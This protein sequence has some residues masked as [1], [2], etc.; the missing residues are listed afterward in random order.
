MAHHKVMCHFSEVQMY[1]LL[2]VLIYMAFI[3]LGLPDSL[4][5]S[6]WPVMHQ[7][8]GVSISFMGILSMIISGGTIISSLMS[9]RITKKLGTNK[10]TAISVFLTAIA[11]MGFSYAKNIWWLIA[12]AIPYGLGAGSIDAA[13]NNYVAIHYSSKHMSWLH[14]F[15]GVGTIISPFIMSYSLTNY[16]WNNGYSI[17]SIIQFII[18]IILLLTLPIWKV[19]S[20]SKA[21][22]EIQ[23]ES[24]GFITALKIK[25]VPSLLIGFFSYCAAECTAMSWSCTYLVNARGIDEPTAAAFA[26]MF[27]IGMTV[28]R[29]IGGFFMDTLGD[30]RMIVLGSSIIGI[31][32]I[33]MMIPN[34]DSLF[35]LIGLIVIGLGCAPIYPCIIHATP[36]NFGPEKSGAIIGIQ[37]ASAYCGATFIPPIFGL[38]SEFVGFELFPVYMAVFFIL[39]LIMVIRTF[40]LTT[41]E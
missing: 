41:K 34:T 17:V 31:G 19:N 28:G 26:S 37:M 21:Q 9:D 18:G 23:T 10:V 33:L 1:T 13:L 2:I 22:E 35:S 38:I 40:N 15:W 6:A 36:N 16:S 39:M 30:K 24:I 3:S 27:F 5:G 7:D 32:L 14:C 20:V 11:L 4:L 12:F 29:F 8:I 25:G